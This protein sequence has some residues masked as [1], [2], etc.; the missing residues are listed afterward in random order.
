MSESNWYQIGKVRSHRRPATHFNLS[1]TKAPLMH[2]RGQSCHINWTA[3][4]LFKLSDILSN[5]HHNAAIWIVIA[6]I[7]GDGT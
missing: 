3:L 2:G 4:G 7:S 6:V 1:S 5:E